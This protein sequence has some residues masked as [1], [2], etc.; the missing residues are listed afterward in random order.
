M[1]RGGR[2]GGGSRSSGGGSRGSSRSSGGRMSSSSRGGYRSSRSSSSSWNR[3][4]FGGGFYYGG[5]PRLRYYHDYSGGSVATW[6]VSIIT[7]AVLFIVLTLGFGFIQGTSDITKSTLERTPL[8]KGAVITTDYYT[9]NVGWVDN[10]TV[11]ENGMKAFFDET[12]VQPYLYITDVVDG[13]THPSEETLENF[14]NQLYDELFEDEAHFLL[15]FHEYNSDGAYS[16]WYTCGAQAKTVMDQEAC[17][18]LLD[19]VD[20]YYFSDRND[21]QMFADAFRDAGNRIMSKTT[22]FYLYAIGI[23]AVILIAF[24]GFHWWKKA[25]EQKNLEAEQTARILDAD[26]E[27]IGSGDSS[28]DDLEDKYK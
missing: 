13:E 18:I 7:I 11:L 9:D 25:K 16:M 21:S 5:G 3:P 24:L 10:P 28:I 1:A 19:Y 6:A 4:H 8:D 12:G 15:V 22:P 17:D 26:L 2:G 14:T 27:T 20:S 23:I